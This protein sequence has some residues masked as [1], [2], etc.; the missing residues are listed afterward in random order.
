VTFVQCDGNPPQEPADG[1][2]LSLRAL[3][4]KC[5]STHRNGS[6]EPSTV[7][8]IK[9][10]FKHLIGTRGQLTSSGYSSFSQLT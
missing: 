3:R 1:E 6:L 8:G 9:L 7:E 5:L 10:H 4:E 2:V